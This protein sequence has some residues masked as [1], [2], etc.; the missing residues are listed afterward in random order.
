MFNVTPEVLETQLSHTGDS[1]FNTTKFGNNMM[2]NW[3]KSKVLSGNTDYNPILCIFVY[4]RLCMLP[5]LC[6]TH[7]AS[8]CSVKQPRCSTGIST[9]VASPSCGVEV[10][11]SEGEC[12]SSSYLWRS[13]SKVT[14]IHVSMAILAECSWLFQNLELVKWVST[15]LNL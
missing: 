7:K 4:C 13:E 3:I 10:V 6:H 5:R 8:C 15:F 1:L 12:V 9:M 14:T 11:S 2:K